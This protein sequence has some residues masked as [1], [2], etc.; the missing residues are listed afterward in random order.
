MVSRLLESSG[1]ILSTKERRV[2]NNAIHREPVLGGNKKVRGLG[3]ALNVLS[4]VLSDNG[5]VL[6]M[7][8]GDLLLG[9]KGSRALSFRRALPPGSDVF[10]EGMGVDSRISFNW[11]DL[12]AS[13]DPHDKNY[14]IIVYLA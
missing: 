3:E 14:E 10:D 6:D 7:V 5:F 4:R 2:L 8:Y 12:N 9:P 13:E 1:S 11:E